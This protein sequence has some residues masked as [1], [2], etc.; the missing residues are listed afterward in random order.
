MP[1][2]GPRTWPVEGDSRVPYWVYTDETS[3]RR[4]RGAR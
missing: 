2:P 3:Y 4:E 1:A